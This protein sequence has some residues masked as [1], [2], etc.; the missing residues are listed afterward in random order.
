MAACNARSSS[1]PRRAGGRACSIRRPRWSSSATASG[2]WSI[3][4]SRRGRSPRSA[5]DGA[6]HI[7]LTHADWDHV[8]AVGV[9]P[10]ARGACQRRQP[11]SGSAPARRCGR[12]ASTRPQFYVAARGS[13]PAAGGRGGGRG[14]GRHRPLAGGRSA[15]RPATPP[16]GLVTLLPE[17]SLLI[18]GDYLS[19]LE[20]P[21][22]YDSARAYRRDAADAGRPDRPCRAGPRRDRAR[23][24][25]PTPTRRAASPARTWRT[26]SA[27]WPTPRAAA[28]RS[29]RTPSP[30]R[31]APPT[32][33]AHADNVRLACG[34]VAG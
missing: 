21:F 34:E 12:C 25:A 14:H 4:A 29:A 9:L 2:C 5:G 32:A 10:D 23:P 24:A 1:R 13:R 33:P 6:G 16:D 20:I 27:C 8:M 3:P 18:V 22:V 7:L 11:P 28:T 19:E 17:E 15:T 26:W 31:A 30:S